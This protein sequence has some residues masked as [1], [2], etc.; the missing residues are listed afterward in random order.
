MYYQH[1]ASFGQAW[2]SVEALGIE[3]TSLDEEDSTQPGMYIIKQRKQ[4]S[5]QVQHLKGSM[6]FLSALAG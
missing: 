4:L 3:G 2:S 1:S 5:P 6:C